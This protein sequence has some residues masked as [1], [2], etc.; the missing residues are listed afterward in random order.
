MR[1]SIYVL[2]ACLLCM[3]SCT[4]SKLEIVN[5]I[6]CPVF[7][8]GTESGS[9]SFHLGAYVRTST[10]PGYLKLLQIYSETGGFTW[11]VSDFQYIY[12]S[13]GKWAG[14]SALCVPGRL[15]LPNGRIK[16]TAINADSQTV[17][18][19]FNLSYPKKLLSLDYK[20]FLRS[21]D[22]QKVSQ[23]YIVFYDKDGTLLN[24]TLQ[25]DV[26]DINEYAKTIQNAVTARTLWFAKD[27]SFAVLSPPLAL[28][29]K[30]QKK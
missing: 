15:I 12:S 6:V 27:K 19:T 1:N 26:P 25:T 14:S 4:Q 28:A 20:S 10:E 23:Q 2:C 7:S 24:C 18:R 16:L 13:N 11:T 3:V 8:Y 9:P 30:T 22:Y 5:S 29:G 17:E 21:E